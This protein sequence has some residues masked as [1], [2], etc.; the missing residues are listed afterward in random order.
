MIFEKEMIKIS[1]NKTGK[2]NSENISLIKVGYKKGVMK[3]NNYGQKLYLIILPNWNI[4]K[5]QFL[6]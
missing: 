3:V 4:I 2:T 5:N 1:F 6:V